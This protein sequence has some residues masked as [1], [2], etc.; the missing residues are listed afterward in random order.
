MLTEAL[1]PY[2]VWAKTRTPAPLDLAGSNLWPCALDD[3][4]GIGDAL[5]LTAPNDNGYAPLREAIATHVGVPAD[6]IVNA[7]GCSGA[8]FLTIAALVGAGDEVIMERPG[9]DPLAGACRLMGAR[10]KTFERRA[11]RRY[12]IDLDEVRSH[13]SIR[14]RLIIVTSPHNPSGMS[15][16][17]ETLSALSEL[18][19]SAGAYLLVDEVYLDA[20]NLAAG[21]NAQHASAA[22]VTG[23]VIATS[24]LTKSFGLAGL[25]CGWVVAPPTLVTRLWRVRDLVEVA[26]SA[27]AD[28]LSAFAFSQMSR[29]RERTRV[30]LTT[31]LELA[32]GFAAAHTQLVLPAPPSATVIFPELTGVASVD[33]FVRRLA[34]QYGVAVAPGRF[35][36]SPNHFRISLAGPTAT[37]AEGLSRITTAL[38]ES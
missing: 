1:A 14:T 26:G 7:T 36:D 4:P 28:R 9:Y 31:N 34:E 38:R 37:L 5:Q 8:N 19:A 24:S 18:A 3:L 17:H 6:R 23:P 30:I 29:L 25:R 12:A 22:H 10:V 2:M 15:L 13:L 33:A 20:V 35:F 11:A 27:V 16:S 32:R 21:P